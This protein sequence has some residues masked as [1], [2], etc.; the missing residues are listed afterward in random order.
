MLFPSAGRQTVLIFHYSLLLKKKGKK[1][2]A[3]IL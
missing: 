3:H 1:K 2:K